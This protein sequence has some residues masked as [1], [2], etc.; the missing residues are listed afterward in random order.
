MMS[1][2]FTIFTIIIFKKTQTLTVIDG[3]TIAVGTACIR[4]SAS[5][6]AFVVDAGFLLGTI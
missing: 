6:N 1:K 4:S 3:S 2:L 5:I